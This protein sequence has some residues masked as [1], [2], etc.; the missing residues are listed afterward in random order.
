[1]VNQT[2][3]IA[4]PLT[5]ESLKR[6]YLAGKITKEQLKER[7]ESIPPKLDAE[8]YLYITSEVYVAG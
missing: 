7:V 3:A 8:D 1:M 6:L 2:R 5:R 4:P